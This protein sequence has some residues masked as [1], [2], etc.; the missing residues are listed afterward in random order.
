MA[1]R[2]IREL[3]TGIEETARK[4]GKLLDF[5]FMNDASYWQ[6]PLKSYGRE[7]LQFLKMMSREWDPDS[8]LQRLQNGGF[9]VSK[10]SP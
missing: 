6:N 4:R 1:R 8:L 3:I 9:L 10:V 7:S 5:Y 2:Q